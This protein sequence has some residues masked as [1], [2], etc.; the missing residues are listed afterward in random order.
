MILTVSEM[1]LT[2]DHLII[3]GNGRLICDA[4][5]DSFVR[6]HGRADVLVRSADDS[7]LTRIL[8]KAGAVAI[9]E[10]AGGLAVTGLDAD[11]IGE[12]AA[13]HQIAVHELSTRHAG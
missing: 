7:T 9:P 8:A 6:Q 11:T 2:A 3:I 10:P 4:S 5:L 13:A 12:V 1:A